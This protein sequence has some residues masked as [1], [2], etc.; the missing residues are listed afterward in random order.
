[1]LTNIA[2]L[3]AD[4]A[5]FNKGLHEF[6]MGVSMVGGAVLLGGIYL[7]FSKYRVVGVILCIA[8]IAIIAYPWIAFEPME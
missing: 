3:A 5:A 4:V 8:A 6:Q 7:L 2:L 1:M